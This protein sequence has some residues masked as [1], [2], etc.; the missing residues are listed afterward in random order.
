[1]TSASAVAETRKWL[2]MLTCPVCQSEIPR[3]EARVGGF[4]CPACGVRLRARGVTPAQQAAS[5]LLGFLLPYLLGARDLALLVWGVV[6]YFVI[7]SVWGV[8]NGWLSPILERDAAEQTYI[9][10]PPDSAEPRR[11]DPAAHPTRP[12]S[13]PQHR[14]E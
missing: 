1:M 6:L 2:E 3:K 4:R 7:L 10:L 12:A 14:K 8:A 9:I 11:G 13:S 5:A